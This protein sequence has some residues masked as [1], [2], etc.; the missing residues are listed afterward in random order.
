MPEESTAPISLPKVWRLYFRLIEGHRGRFAFAM[1]CLVAGI[2]GHLVFVVVSGRMVDSTLDALG[3]AISADRGRE[4]VGINTVGASLFLIMFV[5][6][7][8]TF[9]DMSG[10]IALGERAA[11]RLRSEL[12]RHLIELP[13]TF[14]ES[15]RIGD[16][17]SRLL[18]DVALLQETWTNDLRTF[19]KNSAMLLGGVVLL[20]LLSVKLGALVLL[21]VAPIVLVSVWSGA[22]IRA[23]SAA[24]QDRLSRSSVIVEEVLTAIRSVKTFANEAHESSRFR[25]AIGAYLKPALTV[26]WH[27][28]GFVCLIMLVLFSAVIGLL[29]VGA[30]EIAGRGLTP[31]DFTG[32]MS[33]L[34]LAATS[35]GLLAEIVARFQRM[36]GATARILS[37]LDET[38]ED[39]GQAKPAGDNLRGEIA[40]RGVSFRYPG[41]PEATVLEGFDL[42]VSPGERVALVG[43]SGAGK[44][45][46]A[47][48]L[49]RL[50]DPDTGRLEIDG[51]DAH[52][53]PLGWLRGQ[54]AI[55]PQEV[56][57][58]GGSIA[59]NIAY[60]RPGADHADIVAA[61]RQ[62]NALEFIDRLPEGFETRV[63]DRGVQLSGGQ[64]QRIAIARAVLKNPRILVLDEAT[65]SLDPENE[66]MVQ[67]AL[68]ELMR[69]RTTLVI[70]HRLRTVRHCDRIVVMREGRVV[71]SG[72]HEAL[73]AA[74]GHY[75][76]LCDAE[77]TAGDFG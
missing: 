16:L 42:L 67:E 21:T 2:V 68:E 41:R 53:F 13:M 17:S 56:L 75:R 61:A 37:L 73:H 49:F 50:F 66:L 20:F 1:A 64:R 48:L 55:V 40:F 7:A 74:D 63:G 9:A 28:A 52:T 18:A 15:S 54:M 62:A 69:G 70:A 32:F 12:F 31:G 47:A 45:T 11:A 27:R 34:V 39:L 3:F 35:G 76:A 43:P 33:A 44:S 26:A 24:V 71:E 59:E 23:G 60:G 5:T 29:W 46:V 57:L 51:R 38:A 25:E 58:F 10:F 65:S 22:R 77:K 19:A 14:F 30:H 36:S 6:L 8:C 4:P 72:A